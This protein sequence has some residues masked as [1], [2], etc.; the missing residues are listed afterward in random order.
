MKTKKAT[1]GM[2]AMIFAA[3]LGTR[4]KPL[5]DNT[6]KALVKVCGQPLLWHVLNRLKVAGAERIVVNVHHFSNQ[7][8]EYLENNDFPGLDIRISDESDLLLDTGGGIRKAAPLFYEDKPI[9]IH[10]VDI[11]SNVNIKKFY[12]QT[13]GDATLLVSTL[14]SI[15]K[16]IFDD[17][18]QLVGWINTQTGEIKSPYP[19]LKPEQFHQYG[20]SGIH[21]FSPTLFK[22]ME[23]WPDRFGII[24]LYL[25]VCREKTIKGYLK[26]NLHFID[27]GKLDTLKQAEQFI[28][29]YLTTP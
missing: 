29:T 18:M 25:N 23:S 6:P 1:V 20:F 21:T 28:Q 2:Q 16:L 9:F 11:F 17:D 19:D 4:L 10:N 27:V 14:P 22:M 7:I 13:S 12:S 5:T 15:R 24:D 3:G 8:I 26:K